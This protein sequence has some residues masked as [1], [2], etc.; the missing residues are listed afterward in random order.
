MYDENT[1]FSRF[2][3]RCEG[4]PAW[5]VDGRDRKYYYDGLRFWSLGAR[6]SRMTTAWQAP[7]HGWVHEDDCGCGLCEDARS[8]GLSQ[9]A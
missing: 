9:A 2:Q 1:R 8:E 6:S 7:G 4:R 3:V 5:A